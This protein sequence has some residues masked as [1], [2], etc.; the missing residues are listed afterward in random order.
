LYPLLHHRLLIGWSVVISGA[1]VTELQYAGYGVAL[2]G[3][4]G[5][6][7]FKRAQ[8]V[9]AAAAVPGTKR[10]IALEEAMPL[11]VAP[12]ASPSAEDERAESMAERR[13]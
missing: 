11:A 7:A 3:V 10:S 6:S 2:C 1:V 8:H 12:S 4:L 13:V 5:Y 9:A